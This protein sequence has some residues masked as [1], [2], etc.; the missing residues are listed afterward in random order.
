MTLLICKLIYLLIWLAISS[1]L[2]VTHLTTEPSHFSVCESSITTLCTHLLQKL[3]QLIDV[4]LGEDGGFY[5][6]CYYIVWLSPQS[7]SWWIQRWA[8]RRTQLF[9][10]LWVSPLSVQTSFISNVVAGSPSSAPRTSD[11]VNGCHLRTSPLQR[12]LFLLSPALLTQPRDPHYW[13]S[14]P[15]SHCVWKW[16]TLQYL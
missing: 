10:S 12:R 16:T 8:V 15:S 14:C 11:G 13:H 9:L 2:F 1:Q 3:L 7:A 6:G 5:D 4:T